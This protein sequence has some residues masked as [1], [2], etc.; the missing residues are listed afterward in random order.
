MTDS[1]ARELG[2]GSYLSLTTYRRDGTA[3]A[4]P[5]WVMLGDDR[6]YVITDADSGKAKRLRNSD[7]VLVAACDMRGTISGP[8]HPGSAELLDEAGTEF[9]E[10]LLLRK[11]GWQARA[12]WAMNVVQGLARRVLMRPPGK[13]RVG[14][15][16]TLES[17]KSEPEDGRRD[18]TSGNG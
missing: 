12:F 18:D 9:V 13:G 3:V 1:T 4:T 7:R 14:I 6:L 10:G 16:I 17:A 11:Y 5:V 15:R 8:Q 2:E